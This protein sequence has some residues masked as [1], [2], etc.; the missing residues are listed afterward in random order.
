MSLQKMD[1]REKKELE[2]KGEQ[3]S[4]DMHDDLSNSEDVLI[5]SNGDEEHSEDENDE[6]SSDDSEPEQS[7]PIS[8][9]KMASDTIK[10]KLA[11]ALDK[12]PNATISI[13]F[14]GENWK[15]DVEVVEEE[16]L[17]GQNLKSLNDIFGL[18]EVFMDASGNLISWTKK[19]MY[20]RSQGL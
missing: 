11:H 4:A 13:S 16:Y 12:T 6:D 3:M 14:D 8:D 7:G 19:R 15:A 10:N 1:Y 5:D 17:P 18:Y 2:K 20:K 9:I